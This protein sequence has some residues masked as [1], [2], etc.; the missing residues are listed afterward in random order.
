MTR[1]TRAEQATDN[2]E[3]VLKAARY[4]F[5][6]KGFHAA[7]LDEIA[8]EAG[9]S[10]GVVYSQFGSKDDLFFALLERR[11]EQRAAENLAAVRN[12]ADGAAIQDLWRLGQ[13]AQRSD[14]EWLL[15][16]LEFRIHAARDPRLNQRYAELHGRT[17]A[18]LSQTIEALVDRSGS[19]PAYP[20]HDLAVLLAALDNGAALEDLV[21]D[22]ETAGRLAR[23]AFAG[24]LTGAT[25]AIQDKDEQ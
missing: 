16:V 19:R 14:P 13:A 1:R 25:P 9:F 4:T 8:D 5:R 23:T 6:R 12:A 15:L 18:G 22:S 7:S 24:L 2:R 3:S 20:A 11:I 21:A 10:K 17:L